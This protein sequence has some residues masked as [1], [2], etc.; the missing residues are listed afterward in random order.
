MSAY[1]STV[2][3]TSFGDVLSAATLQQLGASGCQF[4][5]KIFS[6]FTYVY[7]LQDA[8]GATFAGDAGTPN[9]TAN[10][11]RVVFSNLGGNPY[12]P[13]LS[14]VSTWQVSNGNSGD[15]TLQYDVNAPSSVPMVL[16]WVSATGQVS[17][18]NPGVD[19]NSYISVGD[20]IDAGG[21]KNLG[22]EL[23][24]PL[25][26]SGLTTVTQTNSIGYAPQTHIHYI[27]DVFIS[28][29]SGAN[30]AI[31]SQVNQGI[32][33]TPEPMVSLTVGG[34]FTLLGLLGVRNRKK[35]AK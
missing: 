23:D 14:I 31:L 2:L 19:Y 10:Q 26:T 30:Q 7:K 8:S 6:N 15:I 33:E 12:M 20:T 29:G 22:I 34:G 27:K 4:G 28:S 5:D 9:V 11:V 3:C 18:V 24:P 25:T 32:Y 17:N 21:P 16:S 1:A 13:I 35:Q